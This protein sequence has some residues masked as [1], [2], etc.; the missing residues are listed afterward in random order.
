MSVQAPGWAT[1]V[2][3]GDRASLPPA[4]RISAAWAA[5]DAIDEV[6]DAIRPKGAVSS[7]KVSAEHE[8]YFAVLKEL[9]DAIGA[10]LNAYEDRLADAKLAR[11]E[12]RQPD[13]VGRKARFV[14]IKMAGMP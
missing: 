2:P 4:E 11:L 10:T 14:R 13:S 7:K 12:G 1:K 5:L 3:V 8:R 6:L 9:A